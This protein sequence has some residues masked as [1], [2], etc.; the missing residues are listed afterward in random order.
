[1]RTTAVRLS[2]ACAAGLV[3]LA[4]GEV[5]TLDNGIA[6]I[7][8]VQLPAPAVAAGDVLRDSTGAIV[9]IRVLAYDNADQPVSGATATFVVSPIDTGVH[10]D[11]AGV[12]RVS[13]SLRTVQIVGRVGSR[14]QTIA[15]S[16][17]IVAQPDS[18]AATGVLDSLKLATASSGLQVSVTGLRRGARVPSKGIIVHYRITSVTPARAVDPAF[19]FFS[20]GLRT[21]LTQAVD[22]TDASGI[23]S[24]TI[25]A[26]DVNGLTSIQVTATAKSLKGVVLPG[27]P[28]T[29]NIPVKK[30][31]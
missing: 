18:M 20:D 12:V 22:T 1:M 29:F 30:G 5:P 9:P 15:A 3:V 21:D 14:L 6:Y 26:S 19:F 13:D 11:A 25:L 10:I 17:D 27:S 8:P 16:L 7:T 31:T 2:V 28:V 24:R 23:T 4:C